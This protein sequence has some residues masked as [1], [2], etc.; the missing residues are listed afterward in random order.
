MRRK[1]A[2]GNWKMNGTS[3]ELDRLG[4]LAA[5]H[6]SAISDILICPPATL[7]SRAANAVSRSKIAI[8]GQDCHAATSG[9]HTGDTS[10]EML[11]DAGA[12]Q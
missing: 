4:T 1:L 3:A 2:A 9:A 8:G 7:L 10:A 11:K 12:S 5:N 6:A